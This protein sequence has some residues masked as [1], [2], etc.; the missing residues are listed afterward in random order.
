MLFQLLYTKPNPTIKY[1]YLTDSNPDETSNDIPT[2][3]PPDHQMP[4]HH[5]HHN[6][7]TYLRDL[8]RSKSGTSLAKQP[9]YSNLE[10]KFQIE[11]NVIGDRKFVWKILSFT[12]CSRT[13]GGG[14]QIG[15][16]R[17]VEVNLSLEEKEVS[18][19][20]CLG[21]PPPSR[22]RRCGGAPCPPRWRAA[23]W[24]PCPICGPAQRTRIVGCVQDHARGITKVINI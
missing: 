8:K 20:H 7:E 1:E 10:S 11:S 22:R 3:S 9:D 21:P 2:A 19:I 18:A 17:C 5:R 4:R 6:S 15:K 24:G 23:A 12:Q 16:F 13:C 14:L